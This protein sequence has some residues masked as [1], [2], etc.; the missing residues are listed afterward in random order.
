[1]RTSPVKSQEAHLLLKGAPLKNQGTFNHEEFESVVGPSL[2]LLFAKSNNMIFAR[3]QDC[4][5]SS[6]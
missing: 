4:V 2:V 1:M 5:P 6:P 3:H